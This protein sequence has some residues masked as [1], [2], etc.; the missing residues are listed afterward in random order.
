MD[1]DVAIRYYKIIKEWTEHHPTKTVH[2]ISSIKA[3]VERDY[4]P[5]LMAKLPEVKKE[6]EN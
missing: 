4:D 3:E 6:G 5:Y 1:E 2:T